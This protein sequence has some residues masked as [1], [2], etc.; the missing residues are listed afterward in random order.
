MH[1]RLTQ[2]VFDLSVIRQ[3]AWGDIRSDVFLDLS[4]R[5]PEVSYRVLVSTV[6]ELLEQIESREMAWEEWKRARPLLERVMCPAKPVLRL[7]DEAGWPSSP[8]SEGP[9][10]GVS[11][12]RALWRILMKATSFSEV[13][14][15]ET[16]DERGEPFTLGLEHIKLQ[17]DDDRERYCKLVEHAVDNAA[18]LNPPPSQQEIAEFLIECFYPEHRMMHDAF[19]LALARF[20]HLAARNGSRYNP[21]KRTGDTFD[22]RL[23]L[24]LSLPAYVLTQ[25]RRLRGHVEAAGSKQARLIMNIDTFLSEGAA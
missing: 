15:I 13:E 25:D 21:R 2:A 8:K 20:I 19:R 12:D 3:L 1:T 17:N 10:P 7:T 23:L 14:E 16:T 22:A 18:A 5:R 24:A 9:T 6:A 4:R 11:T